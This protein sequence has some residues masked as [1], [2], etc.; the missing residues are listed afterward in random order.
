MLKDRKEKKKTER[1]RATDTKE[2]T[3]DSK[4]NIRVMFPQTPRCCPTSATVNWP[5]TAAGKLEGLKRLVV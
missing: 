4:R 2:D 3:R 1:Q 5:S